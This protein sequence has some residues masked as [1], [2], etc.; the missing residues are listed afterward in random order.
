MSLSSLNDNGKITASYTVNSTVGERI[1]M[2]K[3]GICIS[4]G[5]SA[6]FIVPP[7]DG[8]PKVEDNFGYIEVRQYNNTKTPGETKVLKKSLLKLLS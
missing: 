4:R 6:L 3:E 8:D 7:K 2:T 5:R 1:Y